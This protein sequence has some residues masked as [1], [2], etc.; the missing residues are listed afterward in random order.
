MVLVVGATLLGACAPE[1]GGGTGGTGNGDSTPATVDPS[2]LPTYRLAPLWE[3]QFGKPVVA[4]LSNAGETLAVGVSTGSG[5]GEQWGIT[6]FDAAGQP[7]WS[8]TFRD[9]RYRTI[10]LSSV[11]TESIFGVALFTYTNPGVLHLYRADRTKLW[12]ADVSSSVSLL[13]APDGVHAYCIDRGNRRLSALDLATGDTL[14]SRIVDEEASMQV[15]GQATVLLVQGSVLS[16]LD[17]NGGTL[18]ERSL[19]PE[20]AG[21]LLAPDGQAVYLALSGPHSA[22]S[23]YDNRGEIAW[24]TAIP[25]GGSNCLA[26]SPDGKYVLA[27]N[28]FASGGFILMQAADGKVLCRNVLAAVESAKNQFIR[29]ARFLPDGGGFLLDYAVVREGQSGYAEDH[30]LLLFSMDGQLR[31]R[32]DLGSNIDTLLSADCQTAATV[33]TALLDRVSPA[34]SSIR[35]YDLSQLLSWR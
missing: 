7:A 26:A 35:Y 10:W 32:V 1:V 29:W 30:Q 22:V 14:W 25:S 28:V 23:R 18:F 33:S 20:T 31:R 21:A 16:V 8:Q 17:A 34:Q 19:P 11:S 4:A 9:A 24:V 2:A 27:Y 5:S 6:V 13:A 12:S 3:Q 15:G